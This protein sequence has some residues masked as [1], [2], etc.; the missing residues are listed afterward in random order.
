M[1]LSLEPSPISIYT[2][3][4][5]ELKEFVNEPIGS[6]E[7]TFEEIDKARELIIAASQFY[8]NESDRQAAFNDIKFLGKDD[9]W[10]CVTM[11]VFQ[12]IFRPD[13]RCLITKYPWFCYDITS[14][15]GK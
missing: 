15:F 13:G 5:G 11:R 14:F 9:F 1:P 8:P 2:S 4:F 7:P 12:K 3:I 10:V 6:F